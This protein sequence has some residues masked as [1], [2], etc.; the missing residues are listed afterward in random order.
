MYI[1]FGILFIICLFFFCICHWRKKKNIRKICRMNSQEKISLLNEL[2]EPFGFS[3]L[4]GE[5]ILTTRVDAWQREFGYHALYDQ[6]ACRFHMIFDCEPIYFHYRNRTW[7]IEIWKGQYGVSAGA[8][9]GI[10]Y[11]DTILSP[12][13][14]DK[15]LFHSISD[16]ELLPVTMQVFYKGS[17]LFSVN[18]CHWWLTGF[19]IGQYC[20]PENMTVKFS[21][22][23][24]DSEMLMCLL[25]SLYGCGYQKQEL[26]ICDHTVSFTFCMTHSRQPRRD[27][28]CRTRLSR[29]QNRFFCRVYHRI[30]RPFCCTSDQILYLY[31]FLPFAFRR[32]LHFRRNR[33]QKRR[34][35]GR[36]RS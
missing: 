36:R 23:C 17:S 34:C 4:P 7:M 12:E 11:A 3:Y 10:Y 21:L 5:D 19:R 28:P 2:T 29:W 8:E 9:I 14:Y 1:L 22:T 30:T 33:R 6:S 15:T 20:E 13:E 31:F 27:H 25:E 18:A 32:M 26:Y 16:P 35:K 24:P